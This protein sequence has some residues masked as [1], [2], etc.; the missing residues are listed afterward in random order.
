[1]SPRRWSDPGEPGSLRIRG[2]IIG[3]EASI[4][5]TVLSGR[6]RMGGSTHEMSAQKVDLRA[7]HLQDAMIKVEVIIRRNDDDMPA[8]ERVPHNAIR[9]G[10]IPSVRRRNRWSANVLT[11]LLYVNQL[12]GMSLT[13]TEKAIVEYEDREASDGKPLGI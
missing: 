4:P 1:M 3:G 11:L 10:S 7:Q 12:A 13:L 6:R 9:A 2:A 5:Y 8:A